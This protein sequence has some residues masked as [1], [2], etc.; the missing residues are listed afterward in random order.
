MSA[1]KKLVY[2][3]GSGELYRLS[4]G[5][6]VNLGGTSG[7]TFFVDGKPL[8]FA[9]GTS[10]GG[11]STNL[12]SISLQGAYNNS[13]PTAQID[14]STGKNFILNAL[15]SKQLVF[16]ADTGKVTIT[17]DLE[18]MGDSTIIEGTISNVDQ[19]NI[20][21]P[22]NLT[23]ALVIEPRPGVI[24]GTDLVN[25][26]LVNGGSPV[27]L[28]D[29]NGDTFLKNLTVSGLING[30]NFTSFVNTVNAHLTTSP[31]IKHTAAEISVQGP[32]TNITGTNVEQALSS[33]NTSLQ[34]A[35]GSSVRTYVHNQPSI[36]MVW[37]V[38][39]NQAS[40]N[41]VVTIYD[42]TGEQVWPDEVTIVDPNVLTVTFVSQQAGKALILLF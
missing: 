42:T 39:H 6:I 20:A 30:I 22:N 5:G 11:G 29:L 9:D 38:V 8:L 37:T 1:I 31:A 14:L 25:L 24:L 21:P 19:L 15:N 3:D 34:T 41:P 23:R 13:N 26:K 35:G 4:D 33:I 28:I 10:T 17:G 2:I 7:P 32:F 16:N 40:L 36:A 12:I 27:F 18:V